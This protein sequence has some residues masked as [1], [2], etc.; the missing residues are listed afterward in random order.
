MG[1]PA[2]REERAHWGRVRELGCIVTG[3]M[4]DVTIH[5]CHSGSIAAMGYNRGSTR[6]NHW[7]VIPLTLRLHSLDP[8]GIDA[9]CGVLT[10]ERKFGSQVAH[11]DTVSL[12][13]GYNVWARAGV[14]RDVI[15]D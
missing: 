13:L 6:S 2:N 4:T 9:G 15:L 3:S 5:H 8:D 1:R 14:E 12:L 10:W 7:L 11:L